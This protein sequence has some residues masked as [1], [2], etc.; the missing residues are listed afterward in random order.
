MVTPLERVVAALTYKNPD[1]VPAG[2]LVCGASRRVYGVTYDVWARDPV[3]AAKCFMAAQE[4]I[5]FD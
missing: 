1:R 3:I 4:M 2:P 5:G